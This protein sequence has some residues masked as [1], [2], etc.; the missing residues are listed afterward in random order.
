MFNFLVVSIDLVFETFMGFNLTGNISPNQG[1]LSGFL[2][3]EL[4]IGNFYFGFVLITL[5]YLFYSFK[6][7]IVLFCLAVAFITIALLIGERSNFI[8]ILFV[9]PLFLFFFQD[10][11]YLKKSHSYI[12][13]I[14]II[15]INYLFK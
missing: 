15:I 7:N 13:F 10:K 9:V 11:N 4:K 1:R 6:S 14:F 12:Y 3:E 5:S 2:G 8:K